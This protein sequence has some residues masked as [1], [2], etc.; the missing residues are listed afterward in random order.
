RSVSPSPAPRSFPTRRSS[1]LRTAT[2]WQAA[3]RRG[4]LLADLGIER[5]L[6]RRAELAG[7]AAG[8]AAQLLRRP[9]HPVGDLVA[10]LLEV[11]LLRS[12][13]YTSELQSPDHFVCRL[14]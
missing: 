2:A 6:G 11:N 7:G 12:E 1:D 8:A 4:R 13:E 3:L 9:G 14:L 5:L 10:D